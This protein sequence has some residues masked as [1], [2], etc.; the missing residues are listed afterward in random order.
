MN[1]PLANTLNKLPQS[2]HENGLTDGDRSHMKIKSVKKIEGAP[3]VMT[4]ASDG[5]VNVWSTEVK[6]HRL[7]VHNLKY[8]LDL[9]CNQEVL[10]DLLT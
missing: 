10:K 5:S 9:D 6:L 1:V 8:A 4:G 7:G 2:V 3:L